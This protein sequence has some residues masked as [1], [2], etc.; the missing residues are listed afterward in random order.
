V[1]ALSLFL[2]AL[3]SL[4]VTDR[5]EAR[6]VQSS[7]QMVQSGDPVDIR[8]QDQ[9]RLK[10]PAGIYWLQAS[11]ALLSGQGDQAPLWVYRLP[12]IAGAVVSVLLLAA[13]GTALFGPSPALLA[14]ILFATGLVIGG[15]ARIA[16]T[17]AMLLASTLSAMLVLARLYM[18]DGTVRTPRR[19]AFVFWLSVAAAILIKGPIG[20]MVLALTIACLAVLR[21]PMH[22]LRPLVSW[23]AILVATFVALPWFLAITWQ[24]SG[25]FWQGSVGADL[26]AKVVSGQEGKG[27]P[28]GSYLVAIWLTFWPASVLLIL[29]LPQIWQARQTKAVQFLLAWIIPTWLLFEAVPTKLLHYTLPTYPALALLAVAFAQP[30]LAK[31][32]LGLRWVAILALLPGLGMGAA[33][34]ILAIRTEAEAAWP[35]A[36]GLAVACVTA[37]AAALAILQKRT[38][39]LGPLLALTGAALMLG[40]YPA[41]ARLP[42]IWPGERAF[43]AAMASAVN[44]NCSSTTVAGWGYAEPSLVWQAGAE[45]QML[46]ATEQ[47][48]PSIAAAPCTFV[49][50]AVVQDQVPA[51]ATCQIV[52][53]VSGFAL[54]AGRWITL[55]VLSCGKLK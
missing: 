54:G 23:Q 47:L 9:Q 40:L 41:L 49:L 46:S 44:Q 14:S 39:R 48:P 43:Q 51:P 25:A 26:M 7:R 5:D 52:A 8:F 42:A 53:T 45:T 24:S 50:R 36:A 35:M 10:K 15:E 34:L 33:V 22:W 28:P 27:A 4:P 6:F 17:D 3:A 21:H 19:Y 55:D 30:G 20:P 1:I 18:A 37:C 2:P 13:I 12:S 38:A 11:A 31:A 16:K 29:A 32:G